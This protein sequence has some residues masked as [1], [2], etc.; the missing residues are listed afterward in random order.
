MTSNDKAVPFLRPSLISHSLCF[1]PTQLMF[2]PPVGCHLLV[3]VRSERESHEGLERNL[4]LEVNKASSNNHER[5]DKPCTCTPESQPLWP[6][7]CST[8]I[9]PCGFDEMVK[10]QITSPAQNDPGSWLATTRTGAGRT[11][12]FQ[13]LWHISALSGTEIFRHVIEKAEPGWFLGLEFR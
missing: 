11:A 5:W 6:L 13:V 10:V 3:R 1:R 8:S 12:I 4:K 7:L 2:Q 9:T